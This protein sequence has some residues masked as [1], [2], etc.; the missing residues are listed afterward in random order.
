MTLKKTF[1]AMAAVLL[2]L[3]PAGATLATDTLN[4]V[5]VHGNVAEAEAPYNLQSTA[6]RGWGIYFAG[7]ENSFNWFHIPVATPV[8]TESTRVRL[9]RFFVLFEIIGN[10]KIT[11]V[12]VWDGNNRIVYHTGLALS[13]SHLNIDAYNTFP[14]SPQISMLWGMDIVVGVQ[15]GLKDSKGNYPTI[16]FSTAG[17]DFYRT[18]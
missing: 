3:L 12:H 7:K 11:D 10:A 6:V 1:V 4:A 17:A 9:D 13:G 14:V 8:I 16:H 5:W 18:Y 2:L 15:F